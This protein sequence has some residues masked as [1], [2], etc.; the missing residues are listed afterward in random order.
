MR[1]RPVYPKK[2]LS[3]PFYV[4]IMIGF[5]IASGFTSLFYLEYL[6]G[7]I[8]GCILFLIGILLFYKKQKEY[9][10]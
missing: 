7:I 2:V 6:P 8:Y 1:I 4:G 3:N 10:E 5:L 9:G